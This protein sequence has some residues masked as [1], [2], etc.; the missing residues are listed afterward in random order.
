MDTYQWFLFRVPLCLY[1]NGL[2]APEN[3]RYGL[4]QLASDESEGDG[5][6]AMEVNGDDD[7]G[8]DGEFPG[9]FLT[10][11]NNDSYHLTDMLDFLSREQFFV[12]FAVM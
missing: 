11:R 4:S 3:Q 1:F 8:A 9:N 7:L 12:S 6:Y 5:H 2:L 10:L